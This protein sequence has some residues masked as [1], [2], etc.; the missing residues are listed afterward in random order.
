MKAS[1][2]ATAS[3]VPFAFAGPLHP[4]DAPW[5]AVP[6]TAKPPN[7]FN[8]GTV[9][10]LGQPDEEPNAVLPD[11]FQP[12]PIDIPFGRLLYGKIKYY[13]QGEMNSVSDVKDVGVG[14]NDDAK[15]SACGIPD[16]AYQ[17]SKVSIHPYWLKYAGLDSKS[18]TTFLH[19]HL[20]KNGWL[21]QVHSRILHAGCLCRFLDRH[22]RR[23]DLQGHR[24][25]Q[26]R[27]QRPVPL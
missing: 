19:L 2:L 16:N 13:R 18:L 10:E 27:S 21:T 12:R 22:R 14:T 7:T 15:Q 17:N 6:T 3:A 9:M 24:H 23:H 26:Y 8:N 4:R 5:Q 25:L 1:V 20:L 11:I